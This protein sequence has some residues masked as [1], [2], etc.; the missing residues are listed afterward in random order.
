MKHQ[1]NSAYQNWFTIRE[2]DDPETNENE[3]DYAGWNGV[4]ELPEIR[5]DATG[6]VSGFQDH[7]YS[8]IKRWMDPDGDGDPSDG[9]DGWRLDVAEK[10][11]PAF[12]KVF[13]RWVKDI[14]P[15]AY[16]VGEIWW[17]DW[18]RNKMF[19][20]APWLKGDMFDGVMNYRIGRAIKQYII[21]VEQQISAEAFADSVNQIMHDYGFEYFA[22]SQNL[23]SSHDIERLG[24]QIVNPDRWM[25]HGGNPAQEIKFDVR[26]PNRLELQ[27]QKLIA[28]LQILLPG[29]PMIYYGDETG[30]W[31][32]DDPDCRKPMLWVD[33]IYENEAVHPFGKRRVEDIV[34]FNP[35]LYGWYRNMIGLRKSNLVLSRG[36]IQFH[37]MVGE[38]N[39]LFFSRVYEDKELFILV[40]NQSR[41]VHRRIVL[42]DDSYREVRDLI[43]DRLYMIF[44]QQLSIDLLPFSVVILSGNDTN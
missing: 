17:E 40:N 37:R 38:G 19:N 30:M 6:P 34:K 25:D 16:I 28:A 24:S 36:D 20:A 41:A 23:I 35:D 8:I 44:E 27:K 31:G 11:E 9:I 1:K 21:D 18:P 7:I 3:F 39:S 2:W 29:A 33:Q 14:N 26:K 43:T 15:N 5:E 22:A 10:V 12:W 4:R 32:G 13:R 42:P